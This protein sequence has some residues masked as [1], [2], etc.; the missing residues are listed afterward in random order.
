MKIARAVLFVGILSLWTTYGIMSV[1]VS[2]E[3]HKAE[4]NLGFVW[5]MKSADEHFLG[6]KSIVVCVEQN[7]TTGVSREVPCR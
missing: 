4:E 3:N 7:M 6:R 1:A 5:E 2:V